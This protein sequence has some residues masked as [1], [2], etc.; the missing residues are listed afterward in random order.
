M[1]KERYPAMY[2]K[3]YNMYWLFWIT[4]SYENI[5]VAHETSTKDSLVYCY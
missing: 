5:V 1:Q 4:I 3:D 2:T